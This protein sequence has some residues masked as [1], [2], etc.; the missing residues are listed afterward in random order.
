MSE[1]TVENLSFEDALRSL[2]ETVRDLEDGRLGLEEALARYEQGIRLIRFC[3]GRLQQAEQRIVQFAGLAEGE[4]ILTP[5][6]HESTLASSTPTRKR[7][8]NGVT[9]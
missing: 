6:Q 8:E 9:G 4:P 1:P 5:F 2:E 3:Q 7:R